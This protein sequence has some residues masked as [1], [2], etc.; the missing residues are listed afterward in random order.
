M[1]IPY[2]MITT[3]LGSEVC[4][5]FTRLTDMNQVRSLFV[6]LSKFDLYVNVDLVVFLEGGGSM[7]RSRSV[8]HRDIL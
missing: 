7:L 1:N 2:L 4:K 3:L 5:N 6:F 8:C